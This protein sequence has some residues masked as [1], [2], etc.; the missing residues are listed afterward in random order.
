MGLII[1]I[2]ASGSFVIAAFGIFGEGTCSFGG[3]RVV[4]IT[5]YSDG[6]GAI[7]CNLAASLILLAVAAY[8][9]YVFSNSGYSSSN[10]YYETPTYNT[11]EYTE[12]RTSYVDNFL[13]DNEKRKRVSFEDEFEKGGLEE[14]TDLVE[15]S[16]DVSD[17]EIQALETE[18]EEMKKRKAESEKKKKEEEAKQAVELEKLTKELEELKKEVQDIENS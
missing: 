4:R 10:S 17:D 12:E 18:L 14:E 5:T 16:N 13:N 3:G 11:D 15:D 9:M 2:F 8:W 1:S 6:S 7:S